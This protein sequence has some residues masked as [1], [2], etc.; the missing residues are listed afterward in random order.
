M[1]FD[2]YTGNCRTDICFMSLMWPCMIY[3]KLLHKLKINS[4]S[5]FNSFYD[6]ENFTMGN[7]GEMWVG[8]QQFH[9]YLIVYW[10]C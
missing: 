7:P 6:S 2:Y 10:A 5:V 8:M 4:V 9:I 1:T 3:R